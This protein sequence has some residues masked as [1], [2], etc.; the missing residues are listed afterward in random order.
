MA[1]MVNN[2]KASRCSGLMKMLCWR[3]S[4]FSL[5]LDLSSAV[6]TPL[7]SLEIIVV[8]SL[9]LIQNSP[10]HFPLTTRDELCGIRRIWMAVAV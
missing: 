6:R 9:T 8:P 10:V 4:R 5:Y 2:T 3:T 1:K 7:G